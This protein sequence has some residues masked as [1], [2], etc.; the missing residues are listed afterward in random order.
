MSIRFYYCDY[1]DK[2]FSICDDSIK[3]KT[4][5]CNADMKELIPNTTDGAHEKHVPVIEYD[6]H[7]VTVTVGEE[8][9]PMLDEHY[10][11]WIK[12]VTNEGIYTKYLL[13]NTRPVA[14]FILQPG[15]DPVRAY[16]YCNIHGLWST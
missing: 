5:C 13:P 2:L 16:A 1:C 4:I 12:L 9:H 14:S 3:T 11:T 7:Y 15:E 6:G 8:L 10:I